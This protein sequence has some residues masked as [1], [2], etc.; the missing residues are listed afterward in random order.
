M[1]YAVI[2][3]MMLAAP[4]W[5][6]ENRCKS[7]DN[8]YKTYTNVLDFVIAFSESCEANPTATCEEV[9]EPLQAVIG[10]MSKDDPVFISGLQEKNCKD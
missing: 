7:A 2:A 4:A 3:A 8:L 10:S 1:K 9:L 6:T 5:A